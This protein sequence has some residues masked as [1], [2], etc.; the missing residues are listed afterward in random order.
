[1]GED[2]LIVCRDYLDLI[3]YSNFSNDFMGCDITLISIKPS[4]L[5]RILIV[6]LYKPPEIKFEVQNWRNMF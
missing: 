5:D 4:N 3:S 1:M 6:S 2:T